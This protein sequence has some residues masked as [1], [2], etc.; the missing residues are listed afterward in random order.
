MIEDP[1]SNVVAHHQFLNNIVTLK[2]VDNANSEWCLVSIF[3][4]NSLSC[5]INLSYLIYH[6]NTK[7]LGTL[8]LMGVLKMPNKPN[9]CILKCRKTWSTASNGATSDMCLNIR[10]KHGY[11]CINIRLVPWE[12]LKTEAE[13]RG[14]Q[15]LPRDLAN[16]NALKNHVRSL[17]LHKN[18]KKKNVTFRV[19][20]C[21]ILF[22]LF[23]DVSRMQFSRTMLVLGPGTTYLVTAAILSPRC[24]HIESCVAVH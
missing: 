9:L 20:S 18:W 12:L 7:Y 6:T 1:F 3:R 23:T 10:I 21:T 14:F 5:D 2:V 11:S 22:R 19:I 16:V 15:H 8:T 24:E 13:G 4:H 17:L